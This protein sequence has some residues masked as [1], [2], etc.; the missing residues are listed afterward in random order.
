MNSKYLAND[1][2]PTSKLND[3]ITDNEK[4]L[5]SR[6]IL[7]GVGVSGSYENVKIQ[8]NELVVSSGRK[9]LK[10]TLYV[11][12]LTPVVAYNFLNGILNEQQI[13]TFTNAG[14][15][16]S[17]DIHNNHLEQNVDS[18]IASFALTLSR[19]I[20]NLYTGYDNSCIIE[21]R[22]ASAQENLFQ[23]IGLSN[24][25]SSVMFGYN[26]L[27]FN[28]RYST[29][30]N[31]E[32][33]KLTLTNPAGGAETATVTLDGMAYNVSI[34]A[35]STTFNAHQISYNS[36]G[37]LGGTVGWFLIENTNELYFI[38]RTDGERN[39]GA[40][41]YSST[42]TS[43]GTFSRI[44]AGSSQVITYIPQSSWNGISPMVNNVSPQNFNEYQIQ[45][46]YND[47]IKWLIRN[48]DTLQ[49]EVVHSLSLLNT[50]NE[51]ISNP[52][53]QLASSILSLSASITPTTMEVSNMGAFTSGKINT[54]LYPFYAI[55]SF[56]TLSAST[57]TNI[58]CLRNRRVV[59]GTI[60]MNEI[61]LETVS[62]SNEAG[63]FITLF[64]YLNPTT[65]GAGTT[66]DYPQWVYENETESLVEYDINSLTHTG[67][68][69]LFSQSVGKTNDISNNLFPKNLR[70]SP[71]DN[72]VF[73]IETQSGGGGDVNIAVSWREIH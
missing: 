8:N 44:Y 58:L 37:I 23:L 57:S 26:G 27:N 31:I 49:F 15:S 30:G 43:A 6:S 41:T 28:V 2:I 20:V 16:F 24:L 36:S 71:G 11:E 12:R 61:I 64:I 63:K 22:F 67:G 9:D 73:C 56:K 4:A 17:W 50:P 55:N 70:L 25:T 42:G 68:K 38:A 54:S 45:Y 33:R 51:P 14:G 66:A 65:I 39:T 60:N 13:N 46:S 35:G 3:R 48:P 21:C 40:Y 18:Q 19:K 52:N 47:S 34:T 29:D 69:L 72:Y 1:E 10:N 5:L 7:T 32:V 59:N 62:V 53:F